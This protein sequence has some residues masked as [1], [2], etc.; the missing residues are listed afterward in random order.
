RSYQRSG[1]P[2]SGH[3]R[4]PGGACVGGAPG[5]AA[6]PPPRSAAEPAGHGRSAT[7][8]G[9]RRAPAA[10][11][12]RAVGL[13]STELLSPRAA[14]PGTARL[15]V[16]PMRHARFTRR[17]FFAT[18]SATAAPLVEGLEAQSQPL[19]EGT[20]AAAGLPN[21]WAYRRRFTGG[22]LRTIAFALGRLATGSNG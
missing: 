12:P 18:A 1:L 4:Q 8:R 10:S 9:S 20:A 5:Y 7:D 22:A 2:Q 11:A 21:S 3:L 15:R 19:A 13:Q 17:T 6:R 14:A 16:R